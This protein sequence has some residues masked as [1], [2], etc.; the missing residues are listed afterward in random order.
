M[1]LC[2]SLYS[3]SYPKRVGRKKRTHRKKE[4]QRQK[5]N[6]CSSSRG[7]NFSFLFFFSPS[8]AGWQSWGG[9]GFPFFFFLLSIARITPVSV[10]QWAAVDGHRNSQKRMKERMMRERKKETRKRQW[11]KQ[12]KR[13]LNG[14]LVVVV[15]EEG[16]TDSELP[17]LAAITNTHHTHRSKARE[18]CGSLL[19]CCSCCSCPGD[20]GL[21]AHIPSQ[22]VFQSKAAKRATHTHTHTLILIGYARQDKRN[23]FK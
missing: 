15:Q 10:Q 18:T 14:V 2:L 16:A 3:L 9:G 21:A 17:V 13:N 7:G 4:R 6:S 12:H 22:D 1:H 19:S 8:V 11:N 5:Q 20:P 23:L